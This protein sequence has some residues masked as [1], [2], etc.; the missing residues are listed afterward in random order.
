MPARWVAMLLSG[1][2]LVGWAAWTIVLVANGTANLDVVQWI[3]WAAIAVDLAVAILRQGSGE[4]AGG[5]LLVV[6]AGALGVVSGFAGPALLAIPLLAMAGVL[7]AAC[8]RYTQSHPH[9]HPHLPHA[10]A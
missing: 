2:A 6:G 1:V 8:G 5:L 4:L 10:R 7:F 3:V 9:L